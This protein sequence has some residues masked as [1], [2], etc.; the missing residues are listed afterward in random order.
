MEMV[1]ADNLDNDGDGLTDCV[2][3]DCCQQSNCYSSPLC[4]GSPDP[5]DLIQH[6]QPPFSQHPPRLFYD[7][8]RFLIGKE[9]THVIPGDVSFESRRACVIRGQVVAVDGTPLVGVNVSFLH[10]NEYGYTISRQ[11]GSFDLVAVGGISVTLVFDRS[12]FISEKRTLWLPWNRFIIVDKV[13]MQRAESDTPSCDISS[14]ISPNPIV[15][16]SPLTA[17]GGSCPERGTVIPELQVVQE[18]IAIPSSF[19]KLSYLSSRTPGYKTLLRIILTHTT[20]PSG[21]AKVHLIVAVEGRLLQKWFPAA[22][23]LVYTFAWNK[24]DIYG[25]KVS[26]LAEAMV[27]VGYEYETCPDFIL[28]EKR[29]VILQGFEMDASNLG[30]WSINKHHVLNPQSGILH[31]G[32]GENMF[33]SQQPPVISTVMGNGHQRSVS[34]SNC[35]GLALNSKLFAPVALASGP[36]GSVYIGDFNYV[37]RIFPSGNSIGILELR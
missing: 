36:D 24:T 12:P 25:Q 4:Q 15:L 2:D 11:D 35:N 26:G 20:I 1:C 9:S 23:N 29:T 3:P 31:K 7:R 33:I 17:F 16:P 14:F 30:G 19:V 13:V 34:C 6:S 8:I 21:M 22:A 18:E 28:W 27:S 32:N 37:R 5:L 10:H